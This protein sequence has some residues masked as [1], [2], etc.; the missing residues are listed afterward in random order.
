[1]E[2]LLMQY[3]SQQES[4]IREL[5]ERIS[6]LEDIVRDICC[7]HKDICPHRF[8]FSSSVSGK[9]KVITT[10]V[11]SICGKV[12]KEVSPIIKKIDDN[13]MEVSLDH[14]SE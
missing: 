4:T 8:E 10:Y 6:E 9:D 3:M 2:R 5:R 14:T 7:D 11:C 1:M 12:H 13:T